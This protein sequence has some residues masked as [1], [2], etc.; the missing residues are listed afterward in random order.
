MNAEWVKKNWLQISTAITFICT[1]ASWTVNKLIE[2][3]KNEGYLQA[4]E[5]FDEEHNEALRDAI[6]YRAKYESCCSE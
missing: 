4:R 2:G 1:G 6:I 3:A 5:Q